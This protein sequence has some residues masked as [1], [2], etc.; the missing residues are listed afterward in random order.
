MTSKRRSPSSDNLRSRCK[1]SLVRSQ[2]SDGAQTQ[3]LTEDVV[4]DAVCDYLIDRGWTIVTRATAIQ[5]GY[6]LEAER[7]GDR[8]IAEAK[9]A[10]SSKSGTARFGLTFSRN[11][12]FDHVAKAILKALRV[13]TLGGALAAIALPDNVDHRREVE[14]VAGALAGAEVG[15][16]WVAD[17]RSVRL[18]APWTA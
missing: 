6:D 2:M 18:E 8:L 14:L 12:V 3:I 15:V 10:G 4:V 17:D 7:N 9:G 1:R 5:H 16:F 11:Q 13:A